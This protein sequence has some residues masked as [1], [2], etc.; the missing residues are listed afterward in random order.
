MTITQKTNQSKPGDD[1]IYIELTCPSRSL[2]T[3]DHAASGALE[4][5]AYLEGASTNSGHATIA[6]NRKWFC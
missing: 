1:P 4:E 2:P 3:A 6:E 5:G